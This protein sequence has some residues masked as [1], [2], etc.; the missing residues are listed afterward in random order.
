MDLQFYL[1]IFA[2]EITFF[3]IMNLKVKH[4]LFCFA[5]TTA[6][7]V[8]F[9]QRVH[10]TSA[11]GNSSIGEVYHAD[12]VDKHPSFPGG[13][14]AMLNFINDTRRYP[15]EAYNRRVQGRVVCSVVVG[16]DGSIS[17]TAIVRGVDSALDEEALRVISLMPR[18]EPAQL[19]GA[20]VSS[21]YIISIPF[22]L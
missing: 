17:H 3:I 8:S 6:S 4:I 1:F 9:A 20:S 18:W 21:Y 7:H 5:F 11:G 15:C 12:A 10:H 14:T 13:D 16:A 19:N 22:R 2:C